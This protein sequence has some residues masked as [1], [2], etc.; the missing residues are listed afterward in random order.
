MASYLI[1]GASRGIGLALSEALAA[2]PS[3]EVSV[4]F[5]AYRTFTD[6]LK[7]LVSKS[8][9]RVEAVP[10]D[11]VQEDQA[12]KAA[13]H[14]EKALDGKGLD[15]LVNNAGVVPITPGGI[16]GMWVQQHIFFVLY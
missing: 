1:T 10:M 2:K 13:A 9:G 14:V 4:V 5:A 12:K 15:V 11:V 3:S 6:E 16:V 7:Q 8:N